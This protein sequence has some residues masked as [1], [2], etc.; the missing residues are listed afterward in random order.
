MKSL[1]EGNYHREA[2]VFA[3]Y[4]YGDDCEKTHDQI[5]VFKNWFGK[6]SFIL[7]YNI[8]YHHI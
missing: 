1:V 4:A 7:Y 5:K 3:R 6:K 2:F 8:L